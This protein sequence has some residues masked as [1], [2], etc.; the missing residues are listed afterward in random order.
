MP[1]S[2]PLGQPIPPEQPTQDDTGA[3]VA[4]QPPEGEHVVITP[5]TAGSAG[6]AHTQE[7]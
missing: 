5:Q 2:P 7:S 3:P 4:G 6:A 1:E